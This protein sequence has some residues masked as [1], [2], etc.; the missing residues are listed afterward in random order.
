M[1]DVGRPGGTRGSILADK[2]HG[3]NQAHFPARVSCCPAASSGYWEVGGRVGL[4]GLV[5][6][7]VVE[8]G[9]FGAPVGLVDRAVRSS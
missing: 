8:P 2:Q 5:G 9:F 4:V 3:K 6:V 1:E 7:E